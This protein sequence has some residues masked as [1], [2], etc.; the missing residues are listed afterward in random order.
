MTVNVNLQFDSIA[1][2]IRAL[3]KL[4]AGDPAKLDKALDRAIDAALSPCAQGCG[5]VAVGGYPEDFR[6]TMEP[7]AVAGVQAAPAAP[8]PQEAPKRQRRTKAQIAA[9]EAANATQSAPAAMGA[10][11]GEEIKRIVCDVAKKAG[12]SVAEVVK[13]AV[14]STSPAVAAGTLAGAVAAGLVEPSTPAPVAVP[15][16]DTSTDTVKAALIAFAQKHGKD[17]AFALLQKYGA[18]KISALAPENRVAILL[19]CQA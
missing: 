10:A 3:A 19:D 12:V 8:A 5:G 1:D 2:A 17:A 9:D 16:G 7:A 6:A 11:A 13:A 15:V 14:G 4:D 18:D